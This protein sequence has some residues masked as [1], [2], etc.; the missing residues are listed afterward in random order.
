MRISD[1]SSDVCSSDLPLEDLVASI[2]AKFSLHGVVNAQFRRAEDGRW[3]LI[4]INARPAGGVVYADQ[5]G[6]SLTADWAGL[7][8]GRLTPTT[9][10]RTQVDPEVAFA[11]VGRP[12]AG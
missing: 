4:E 1:W 6:C 11:T 7:L 2:V 12:V 10:D 8:T 9:I 3:L 5:V